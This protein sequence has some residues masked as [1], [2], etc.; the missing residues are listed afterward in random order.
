MKNIKRY[1]P[2]IRETIIENTMEAAPLKPAKEINIH[3]FNLH[4]KGFKT[5]KTAIGLAIKVIK[6][7]IK[8]QE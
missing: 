5:A 3:W 8:E 1:I 2:T 6:S 7:A 4:L